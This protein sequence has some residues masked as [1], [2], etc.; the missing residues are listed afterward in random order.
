MRTPLGGA[1]VLI[2][3]AA[4]GI[5]KEMAEGAAHRG[6]KHVIVWDIDEEG[7]EIAASEIRSFGA[8]ATYYRVD[9]TDPDDVAAVGKRVL[10]EHGR[11]DVLINNAGIVTGKDFLDLT[12]EEIART[13]DINALALYRT[14]R[15]FLPGMI[16]RGK[17]SVTTIASAAGLLGVARQTDYSASKFA[18]VGFTESLRA[19][20]RHHGNPLHTLIVHPYYTNTRMFDGVKSRVSALL[21][22]LDTEEVAARILDAIEAGNQSLVMPRFAATIRLM[23]C[24]PVPV[25]DRVTDLFGI[26][27]TMDEFVG[28]SGKRG[29]SQ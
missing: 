11:V 6:A 18:A 2:T 5:G 15:V 29:D 21:P 26:H 4:S 23:K 22:I 12:E 14:T 10:A 8:D 1:V 7:G 13:F 17:G 20:L 24:L 27:S 16:E 28:H 19:E 3:G 9:L 25:L